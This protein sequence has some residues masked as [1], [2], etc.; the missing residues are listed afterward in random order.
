MI[1]PP[2]ARS[3]AADD[4]NA[5]ID[6]RSQPA[7]VDDG[8]LTGLAVCVKDVI[9]VAGLPTSAGSAAWRREPQVD[10]EAVARLRAA[11][12]SIAGKGNTNEFALGIDGMNPHHGDCRNPRDLARMSGGSSSGPAAAVAAGSAALG[13]GTDTTGS[14]RVPAAFCGVVGIRPT[15]GSVPV[16]G[17]VSLAPSYD[18]VGP[19][20][21]D[22]TTAA[23]ALGVLQDDHQLI[24]W[25]ASSPKPRLK[26]DGFCIGMVPGWHVGRCDQSVLAAFE[27]AMRALADAGAAVVELDVLELDDVEQ[28]HMIIQLSEAAAVHAPWFAEQRDHYAPRV[29]ALLERGAGYPAAHIAER[30]AHRERVRVAIANLLANGIDAIAM[31]AAPVAALS[32]DARTITLADGQADVRAALLALSIPFS[33]AEGP[34]LALPMGSYDGLPLGLQLHGAASDERGLLELALAVEALLSVGEDSGCRGA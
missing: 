17:V 22:V 1:D 34:T 30:R 7:V 32:R 28:T 18:A 3:D 5:Y 25:T 6:P 11:G 13:L 31:P 16:A 29:R 12:A 8:V 15:Y 24:S 2:H 19:I 33:Q 27:S 26:L 10:A 4:I 9:H 23:L 21:A 20:A 14:L